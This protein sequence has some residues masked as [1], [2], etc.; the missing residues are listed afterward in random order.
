M[1]NKTS[2]IIDDISLE[3]KQYFDT[4]ETQKFYTLLKESEKRKIEPYEIS[5][6]NKFQISKEIE[7]GSNIRDQ[8]DK[9]LTF[10]DSRVS[11]IEFLKLSL[12]ITNLLINYGE[13]ELAIDVSDDILTRTDK[14][15]ISI[16]GETY[17][18][19]S[20]IAWNMS[21]WKDSIS[22]CKK[23]YKIFD[24]LSDFAGMTKCENMMGTIEGEKGNIS[25]SKEH[26]EKAE[27]FLHNLHNN[28]LKAMIYLNLGVNSNIRG[29]YSESKAYFLNALNYY[30]K[31]NEPRNLARLNHNIGMLYSELNENETAIKYFNDSINI[32]L[33]KGYLSNCAI[34]FIAKAYSYSQLGEQDLSDAFAEKA[35]EISYKINDRLSIADAYRVKGIIQKNLNNFNLSE[36][37]FEN[38]IRLN[39]DFNNEINTAES[40]A[41]LGKLYESKDEDAKSKELLTKAR[42]FYKKIDAKT[43]LYDL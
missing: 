26:F 4:E 3:L 29:N 34:S 13:L 5:S 24:K 30:S 6:E 14:D 31:L 11:Q 16:L 12:T 21:E 32:S 43:K 19:Q 8:I 25:K 17:L 39:E 22:L 33:E 7:S 41:E 28:S 2:K 18:L 37:F 36:E 9:L 27:S 1:Q 10:A 38:S 42:K 15:Q 23:A 35:L 40:T 20:K